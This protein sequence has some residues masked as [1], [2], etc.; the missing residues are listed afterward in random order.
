MRTCCL[1]KQPR[2]PNDRPGICYFSQQQPKHLER[3]VQR[4]FRDDLSSQTM[5]SNYKIDEGFAKNTHLL[6]SQ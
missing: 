6:L 4:D 1:Q 3:I 5:A 2:L